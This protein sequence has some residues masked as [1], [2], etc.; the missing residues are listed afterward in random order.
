VKGQ[1]GPSS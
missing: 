1:K